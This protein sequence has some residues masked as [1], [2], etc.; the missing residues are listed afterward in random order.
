MID[1]VI[2]NGGKILLDVLG[3]TDARKCFSTL[4]VESCLWTALNVVL[5]G[6]AV[7]KIPQVA[8]AVTKIAMGLGKF[9][10]ASAAAAQTLA[11]LRPIAIVSAHVEIGTIRTL[12]AA[13]THP[14]LIKRAVEAAGWKWTISTGHAFHRAH[15][16]KKGETAYAALDTTHLNPDDIEK[17][18]IL[19]TVEFLGMGGKIAG[20]GPTELVVTVDGIQITGHIFK[21]GEDAMS[22]STYFRSA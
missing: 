8:V 1:W 9:F 5:I 11:R 6:A 21:F 20:P 18:L 15:R 14:T 19:K 17:A 16:A 12:T 22:I 4:D 7:L 10:S 2:E 13:G 3:V